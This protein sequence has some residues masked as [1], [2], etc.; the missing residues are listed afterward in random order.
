L[1]GAAVYA[2]GILALVVGGVLLACPWYLQQTHVVLTRR[3]L[4]ID[5]EALPLK[6]IA[7]IRFESTPGGTRTHCRMVV[8][9]R[10]RS[11][12]FN[13][14]STPDVLMDV[15]RSTG[16]EVDRKGLWWA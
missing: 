8:H 15:L 16:I 2:W 3:V 13:L 10:S 7:R 14:P 9:R 6:D 11:V 1:F 5:G 4:V 12:S